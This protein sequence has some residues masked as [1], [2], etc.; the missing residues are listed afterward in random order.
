MTNL[1]D[2]NESP[3]WISKRLACYISTEEIQLA[4]SKMI[5][6]QLLVRDPQGRLRSS[7][8]F[9]EIETDI[10]SEIWKRFHRNLLA[11]AENS[12][13]DVDVLLREISGLT[14]TIDTRK[15]AQAK[16]YLRNMK[17]E[18]NMIFESSQGDQTYHL[19]INLFPITRNS[20]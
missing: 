9:L 1:Q 16:E 19:G 2:F 4:I 7:T 3:D 14:L 10:A 12:L 20:A 6:K 18:F 8:A 17:K 5:E 13:Q 11:Q 15:I